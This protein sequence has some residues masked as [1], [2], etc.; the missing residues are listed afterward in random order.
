MIIQAVD[1]R[2]EFT[3]DLGNRLEL[4]RNLNFS[5]SEDESVSIVG[6]SGSGKSTLLHLLAGLDLPSAGTVLWFG[7]DIQH[8]GEEENARIRNQKIGFVF[9]FHHLLPEFNALENVM[10]PA[11]IGGLSQHQARNKAR[12]LLHDFGMEAR[13]DHKPRQL[14]GGE[15]QR[16]AFARALINEPNIILAD[17]PTGNLDKEN[18]E[19]LLELM[20]KTREQVRT[21]LILVTHDREIAATCRRKL[22]LRDGLLQDLS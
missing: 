10:M 4:F 18:S 22:I 13:A 16:I 14:S 7:K 6:A 21:A 9:Q 2:K 11:L 1:L 12:D 17:E 15:Q 19:N 8:L 20:V 3:N 5:I